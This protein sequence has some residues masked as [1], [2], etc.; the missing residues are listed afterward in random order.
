MSSLR[1]LI[2]LGNLRRL[3]NDE[4][5]QVARTIADQRKP[6]PGTPTIDSSNTAATLGST[7]P[8]KLPADD[9]TNN[10]QY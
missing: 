6:Q 9:A 5:R 3:S 2:E 10:A 4:L 8:V 7:S 1:P